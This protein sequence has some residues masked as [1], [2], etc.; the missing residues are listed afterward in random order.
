MD[1]LEQLR[2]DIRL[3]KLA[4]NARRAKAG[5][6]PMHAIPKAPKA[7]PSAKAL[8]LPDSGKVEDSAMSFEEW[9]GC[10]YSVR[11]GQKADHFDISGQPQFT[12]LQVQR[13][14]DAWKKWR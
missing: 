11:K 12:M 14:N 3:R 9:K 5:K 10:G 4:Q 8:P 7:S 2:E 6:K 13:T 1:E